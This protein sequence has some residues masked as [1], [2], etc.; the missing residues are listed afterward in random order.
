MSE[1]A[2]G[3]LSRRDLALGLAA[4]SGALLL[5]APAA[6]DEPPVETALA[7]SPSALD[8]AQ[9]LDVRN[10]A[11]SLA[12]ALAEARKTEV[13]NEVDPAFVYLPGTAAR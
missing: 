6:A 11:R 3:P 12:K 7:A 9:R 1:R 10:G 8:P 13:P 5:P 2:Q 4:V